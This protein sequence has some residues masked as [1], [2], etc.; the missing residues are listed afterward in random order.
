[1]TQVRMELTAGELGKIQSFLAQ[2]DGTQRAFYHWATDHGPSQL[3]SL[4]IIPGLGEHGGRY[5]K[6]AEFFC[7]AG[8]DVFCMDL[9]G[10]G[11][12]PGPRGCIISYDGLLDE[13][14]TAIAAIQHRQPNLPVGLWGHSMGGNLAINYLLRRQLLPKCAIAS[15]P[16]LQPSRMPSD[17]YMWFARK[18]GKLFPNYTLKT[19]VRVEDCTSDFEMQ[20][21]SRA[22]GLFH[23]K[24]S[25]RMG[26]ALIDSGQWAIANASRLRTPLLLA[27]GLNDAVTSSAATVQ[28]ALAAGSS[29][30]FKIYPEHKHDLHRDLNSQPVLEYFSQWLGRALR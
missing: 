9:L 24:L 20:S 1:M 7:R 18:L 5:A 26:A 14:E 4:L 8:F 21:A 29:A 19:P 23:R 6:S 28:F 17:T 22:D 15:A 11:L 25:L 2:P 12:S 3:G 30:E 10:H 27:H 16:L 13:I